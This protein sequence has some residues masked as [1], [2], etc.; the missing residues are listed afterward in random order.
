MGLAKE[1]SHAPRDWLRKVRKHA[2]QLRPA[3][4]VPVDGNLKLPHFASLGALGHVPQAARGRL[5][6][7]LLS[8]RFAPARPATAEV[9]EIASLGDYRSAYARLAILLDRSGATPAPGELEFLEA[10]TNRPR[11]YEGTVG[12][13]DY[14]FLTACISILA[15]R[16]VIELG[17]LTGF[18]AGIIAAALQRKSHQH[19]ASWVDTIDL[20]A[21]CPIDE[22]RP[23]G[24]EIAE[25]FPELA[26]RIR[27]HV[28][29]DAS[30]VSRLAER[31]ELELVFIDAGHAHPHPLLDLLQL[32]P[33]VR[34]GG[35]VILHDIQ[36][37]TMGRKWKE[38][39]Q[40]CPRGAP[41]G[42]EWLFDFCP[43]RKISG[44]NIGAIQMPED[45]SELIPFALRLMTLPSEVAEPAAD[46]LRRAILK[47]FAELL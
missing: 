31:A 16:R 11:R 22:T 5:L 18:S 32:A 30:V 40:P 19:D 2:R 45:K 41:F 20:E 28:P 42:V 14:L 27:L 29:H 13:A 39:D 35:W 17:T 37:G 8:S 43:F 12:P 1:L 6:Q 3:R 4:T 38:A 21:K 33:Y 7:C 36:L 34:G 15:P 44:G 26:S 24:F 25:A 46:C 9:C 23:T 47:S 10:V